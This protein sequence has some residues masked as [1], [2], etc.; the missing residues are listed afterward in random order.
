MSSILI[1]VAVA[2]VGIVVWWLFLH[3]ARPAVAP[4]GLDPNDPLM[5]AAQ[6]E[7]RRSVPRFRLLVAQPN[8]GARV[9]VPFVS[10][11][12]TTEFLWAELLSLSDTDMRVRYLTPPVTHSGRLERLHTYTVS[13]LVDW[14]VELLS[15]KYEGGFTMRAML[16]RAHEQWSTLPKELEAEERKYATP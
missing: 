9:K 7:A 12:G 10:S 3:I 14:Q 6:D 2:A 4:L 15:G 11:S 13:D 8:R 1:L 16:V 5:V